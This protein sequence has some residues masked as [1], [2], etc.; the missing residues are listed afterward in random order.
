MQSKHMMFC[1]LTSEAPTTYQRAYFGGKAFQDFQV[2]SK[3]SK[4]SNVQAT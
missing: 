3:L 2:S 4:I 1:T